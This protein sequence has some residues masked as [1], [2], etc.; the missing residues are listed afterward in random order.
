MNRPCTISALVVT[1]LAALATGAPVSTASA[2]ESEN[3]ARCRASGIGITIVPGMTTA[4]GKGTFTTYGQTA[5]IE[6]GGFIKGHMI[7]GPGTF[8]EEG[9]YEGD[10]SGGKGSSTIS[11]TLPTSG[12]PTRLSFPVTFTFRPGWGWKSSDAFMGKL[13]FQ[14]Y[15]TRG[16]CLSTAVTEIQAT[17][18]ALVKS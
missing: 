11:I 8:G 12:G 13:V 7:T 3:V 14:Y 6:C 18:Q 5:K 4:Y 16:D 17:A 1:L 2:S 9:V 15:P 10:C